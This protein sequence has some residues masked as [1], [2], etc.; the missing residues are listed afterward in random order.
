[1]AFFI[2]WLITFNFDPFFATDIATCFFSLRE[3][4]FSIKTFSFISSDNIIEE[5]TLLF[6]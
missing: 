5:G 6:S 4:V 2:A 1:L 3:S